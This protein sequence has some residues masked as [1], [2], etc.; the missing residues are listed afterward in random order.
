MGGR[1]T[2]GG[3]FT[4]ELNTVHFVLEICRKQ[5]GN[6]VWEWEWGA[7]P[8]QVQVKALCRYQ[9]QVLDSMTY[10]GFSVDVRESHRREKQQIKFWTITEGQKLDSNED[11]KYKQNRSFWTFKLGCKIWALLKCT[12]NDLKYQSGWMFY[13]ENKYQLIF[14]KRNRFCPVAYK[15]VI[16][17]YFY[18][19]L[20]IPYGGILPMAQGGE[21][22]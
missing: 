14:F 4:W 15:P 5:T 6:R 9:E 13:V 10:T 20:L 17:F 22:V 7:G 16:V 3:G 21:R 11:C 18:C 1:T 8:Q 19:F 12:C 2:R